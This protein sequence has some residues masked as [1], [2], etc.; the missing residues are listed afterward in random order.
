MAGDQFELMTPA[1]WWRHDWF[2]L[3]LFASDESQKFISIWCAWPTSKTDTWLVNSE[4]WWLRTHDYVQLEELKAQP[5]CSL[6]ELWRFTIP[7]YKS[8]S[9]SGQRF[10]I[11]TGHFQSPRCD[12]LKGTRLISLAIALNNFQASCQFGLAYI[13]TLW[14]ENSDLLLPFMVISGPGELTK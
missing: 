9:Q 12:S 5:S 8:W 11:S 1:A 6:E 7:Q 3:S 4:W 2:C 13:Y 14:T 10:S